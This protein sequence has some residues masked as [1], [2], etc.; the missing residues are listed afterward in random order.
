MSDSSFQPDFINPALSAIAELKAN[1]ATADALRAAV[2]QLALT[3][4]ARP[5]ARGYLILIEP[6][7]TAVRIQ[8]EWGGIAP[9]LRPDLAGRLTICTTHDTH[10]FTS[11]PHDPPAAVLTWLRDLVAQTSSRPPTTR[12]DFDFIILK[13]LLHQYLT[14][15][16]PLTTLDLT[17]MAGCSYPTAR[18]ALDAIAPLLIRRKDRAVALRDVQP[19]DIQRL[20]THSDHARAT[21]RFADRSGQP[22]P[23]ESHLRRLEKLAA[24]NSLTGLAIGGVIGARHYLPALDLVGTPRLDISIHHAARIDPIS[25]AAQIDPAL[26]AQPDPDHPADLVIHTIRHADPLFTRGTDPGS[27]P[28]ADRVECLLDLYEARLEAQAA[29]FLAELSRAPTITA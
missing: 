11:I 27:L 17:R 8:Q 14:T 9:I 22:R 28:I 1:V 6:A 4:S 21:M 24:Q 18:R 16:Q 2:L 20:L 10:T 7:I 5:H 25:L 29:Q 19:R 13:L 3:L 26:V 12:P 15:R 23:P